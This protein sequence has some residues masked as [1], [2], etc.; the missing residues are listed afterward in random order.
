MTNGSRPTLKRKLASLGLVAQAAFVAAA[1]AAAWVAV[2]PL[3]WGVSGSF[4]LVMALLAASLCWLGALFSL[5]ISALL[6]SSDSIMSRLAL[7][8]TARAMV[9]LVLGTGLHVKY[10]QLAAA[11]LILYVVAFYLVAL[12]A[13]TALLVAQVPQPSVSKLVAR[14]KAHLG[15]G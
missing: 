3:A 9:P 12:A 6:R 2:A 13:D 10:P 8:M 14:K 15:H 11:G 1:L 4:G 7:G 5:L